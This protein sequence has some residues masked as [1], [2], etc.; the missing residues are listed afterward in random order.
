MY[1]NFSKIL[2]GI[3]NDI[4]DWVA[5]TR[6]K[7]AQL[8]YTLLINEEDNTTQHLE[9]VLSSLQRAAGDDEKEVIEYV[10]RRDL[11]KNKMAGHEI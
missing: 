1:R 9:K 3:Y 8:L 5:S 2:S 4:V 7:C 6:I 11:H 10:S